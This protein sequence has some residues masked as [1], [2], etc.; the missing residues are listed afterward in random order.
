MGYLNELGRRAYD[1]AKR[2]GFHD[3]GVNVPRALMLIVSEAAEAMETDRNNQVCTVPDVS[4]DFII[5]RLSDPQYIEAGKRDFEE[6]IKNT[7]DDE[8][9]NLVIR[10]VELAASKG[11]DLDKHVAL[12]MLY[13][14]QREYKHGKKY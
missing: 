11:I 3:D 12:K 2:Q 8:L 7:L 9:A 6:G 10:A 13:N 1:Y 4:K 5:A 14:E